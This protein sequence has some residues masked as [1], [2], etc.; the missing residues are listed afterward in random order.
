[1]TTGTYAAGTEVPAE[2]S[3][4]EI[5]RTLERYGATDFG[6]MV[7]ADRAQVAFK[8]GTSTVRMSL[9]LP[10]AVD[11]AR[12]PTNRPRKTD[13]IAA[14][15][16]KAIRQRWRALALAVKA[17]LEAVESGIATFEEEWFAYLVLPDGQTVFEQAGDQYRTAIATGRNVPLLALEPSDRV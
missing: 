10:P 16:A 15:R 3:R 17:K 13:A 9:A 11:F 2:R 4:A 7:T 5:E 1:M 8:I 12:T 6:Y 14:E